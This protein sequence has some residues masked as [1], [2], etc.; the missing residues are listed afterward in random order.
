M[1]YK[2]ARLYKI[3][4]KGNLFSFVVKAL[5]L[6]FLAIEMYCCEQNYKKISGMNLTSKPGEM[7]ILRHV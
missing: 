7:G 2:L 5:H 6:N 1:W 4:Q 3:E